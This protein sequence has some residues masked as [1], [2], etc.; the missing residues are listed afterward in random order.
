MEVRHIF[1]HPKF[2]KNYK[3]LSLKA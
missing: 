3:K 1:T 2:D